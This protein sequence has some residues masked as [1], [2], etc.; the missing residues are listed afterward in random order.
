MTLSLPLSTR[1][2]LVNALADLM[3]TGTGTTGSVSF[4]NAA[5]DTEIA[6][7]DNAANPT[8]P[9]NPFFANANTG[10]PVTAAPMVVS[11]IEDQGNTIAGTIAFALFQNLSGVE[12]FRSDV[13]PSGADIIMANVTPG[14]GDPVR[15]STYEV[16]AQQDN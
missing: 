16:R 7:I 15:L 8:P 1:Q 5:V 10:D 11:D 6:L 4:Q 2:V 14:L 3:E 12:Q 13:A 9:G